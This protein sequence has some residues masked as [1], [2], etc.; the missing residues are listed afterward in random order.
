[1][2]ESPAGFDGSSMASEDVSANASAS[3]DGTQ[4]WE[5]VGRKFAVNSSIDLLDLS[6][7]LKKIIENIRL[8]PDEPKFRSVKIGNKVIQSRVAAREGGLDFLLACGFLSQVKDGEKLLCLESVDDAA[9]DENLKWLLDNVPM[10]CRMAIDRGSADTDPCADC[11]VQIKLPTGSSVSGGF[12]MEEPV[13]AVQSFASCFFTAA[14]TENIALRFPHVVASLTGSTDMTAISL[15]EA[16]FTSRVV[17]IASTQSDEEFRTVVQKTRE[18]AVST[19]A[20]EKREQELKLK[21]EKLS[22]AAER[23][24]E[25]DSI[26]KAFKDDHDKSI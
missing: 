21:Q 25:K 18:V 23:K 20:K 3:K 1:M 12:M 17:L 9:L 11:I 10:C 19:N 16:G 26:L 7:V 14:P 4:I 15:K 8:N 13:Q 6:E 24:A 5:R 2:S 22:K